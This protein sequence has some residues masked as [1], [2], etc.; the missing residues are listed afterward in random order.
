LPWLT[1]L[2]GIILGVTVYQRQLPLRSDL[3][4]DAPHLAAANAFLNG[5]VPFRDFV[6]HYGFLQDVVKPWVAFH[7]WGTSY[8]AFLRAGAWMSGLSAFTLLLLFASI[9]RNRWWFLTA[10][11]ILICRNDLF[12]PDRLLFVLLAA[13]FYTQALRKNGLLWTVLAGASAAAGLLYS[14][15]VGMMLLVGMAV[16]QIFNRSDRRFMNAELAGFAF[17]LVSFISYL[18]W[19]GGLRFFISDNLA[20]VSHYGG[21]WSD[22]LPSHFLSYIFLPHRQPWPFYAYIQQV[23]FLGLAV[24]TYLFGWKRENRQRVEWQQALFLSSLV[25]FQ[26]FIYIGRSDM[27]HWTHATPLIWPLSAMALEE[28]FRFARRS[29]VTLTSIPS[30]LLTGTILACPFTAALLGLDPL[31]LSIAN[32]LGTGTTLNQITRVSPEIPRLGK[33]TAS[34]SELS[35]MEEVVKLIQSHVGPHEAFFDLSSY[36]YYFLAERRNS[37]SFGQLTQ[38]QGSAMVNR[39]LEQLKQSPPKAILAKAPGGAIVCSPNASPICDDVLSHYHAGPR[40]ATGSW[41]LLIPNASGV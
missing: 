24:V 6:I 33:T 40:T 13:F 37:T 28:I 39:C 4:E 21:L 32:R 9:L 23:P 22:G 5:Q 14:L 25:F 10:A 16:A 20:L 34:G 36:G 19:T 3:F 1:L 18:A 7:I 15:D 26:F 17:I 27:V 8:E 41:M 35:E 38:V 12:I 11:F 31:W 29:T 2:L 30:V